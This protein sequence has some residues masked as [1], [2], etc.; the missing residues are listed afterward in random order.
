[1]QEPNQKSYRKYALSRVLVITDIVSADF[2]TAPTAPKM[3]HSHQDAW[4]LVCCMRGVMQV[5]LDE[6][7]RTLHQN[8]L[9]LIRPGQIH[10]SGIDDGRT[11]ALFISFICADN[12]SI[13]LL[14]DPVFSMTAHHR[15]LI[16]II[17]SEIQSAF[18]LNEGELRIFQFHPNPDSLFGSEQM[19]CCC[20]EQLLISL[21][22]QT[23]QQSGMPMRDRQFQQSVKQYLAQS[24]L[25]Y[26]RQHLS[27][28]LDLD[29][30]AETFHYSR[31]RL[32]ELFTAS[33]GT[34]IRQVI[35]AERIALARQL[36]EESDLTVARISE[37]TG[38]A[39]PQ[40]FTRRFH[41]AVGM[42]PSE[43][44]KQYRGS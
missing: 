8:E 32:S 1:M 9:L 2:L 31:S 39:S 42:T 37:E 21:L 30:L 40:Y 35:S 10:D 17:I 34:T 4:E 7:E 12:R 20:L 26:I 41:K 6:E 22:R 13:A 29:S 16:S 19:L 5:Y 33:T 3:R 14:Q 15:S 38:F 27:E 43:Y 18:Q 11:Q 36:L 23:M 28:P 24:V 44:L 25:T